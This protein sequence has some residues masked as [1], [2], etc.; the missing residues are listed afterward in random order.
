[1]KTITTLMMFAAFVLFNSGCCKEDMDDENTTTKTVN[2]DMNANDTYT[3]EVQH[4]GDADD[5]MKI[6]KQAIHS[7][8]SLVTP[9]SNGNVVFQYKPAVD[10]TG[11]DEVQISNVENSNS[12]GSHGNCGH[13]HHHD[14]TVTTVFKINVNPQAASKS[15]NKRT[16]VIID[17]VF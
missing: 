8:S 17:P 14:N 7:S 15:I 4:S 10:Y 16:R 6:T 13:K 12:S 11:S 5:V 1:M 9:A 2:V 3:Y